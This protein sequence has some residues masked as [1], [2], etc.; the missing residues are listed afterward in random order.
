MKFTKPKLA[1]IA[2][3]E[4]KQLA[5]KLHIYTLL[6]IGHFLTSVALFAWWGHL[7]RTG[8]GSLWSISR[9]LLLAAAVVTFFD[10]MYFLVSRAQ[11]KRKLEVE[12]SWDDLTGAWNHTYFESKLHDE[13]TRAGRYRFPISLCSI[14]LDHFR[15]FNENFGPKRGDELLKRFSV[16]IQSGIRSTDILARHEKDIFLL[17]LPHTDLVRA[18][19][20]LSRLLDQSIEELDSWFRAGITSYHT[21]ESP[22]QFQ[23]RAKAA[24]SQ[25]KKNGSK[26]IQCLVSDGDACVA[27]EF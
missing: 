25:A 21:G 5:I 10:G 7:F 18:E 1:E 15:S 20:V 9:I 13:I 22:L 8:E 4:R 24:L 11:G 3:Q 27:V 26:R 16:L 12:P 19:N 2:E 6:V 23:N 14:D 17:L